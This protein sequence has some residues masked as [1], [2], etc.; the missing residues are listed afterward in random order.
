MVESGFEPRTPDKRACDAYHF[1]VLPPFGS[2]TAILNRPSNLNRSE[3]PKTHSSYFPILRKNDCEPQISTLFLLFISGLSA[4]LADFI[5][6]V[7]LNLTLF[8]GPQFLSSLVLLVISH[9]TSKVFWL[10]SLFPFLPF[11]H[12]S[13]FSIL[14]CGSMENEG[15]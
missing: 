8:S 3:S 12:F 9:W 10:S 6:L 14:P 5:F 2:F 1:A 13:P 15:K 4:N 11:P 7:S